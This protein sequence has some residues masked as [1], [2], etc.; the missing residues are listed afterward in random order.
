[1]AINP[2]TTDFV[3]GSILTSAQMN[4]LPRGVI[5]FNTAASAN[6]TLTTSNT[7]FCT[8]TFTLATQRQIQFVGNFPLFDL[9]STQQN[10][11]AEI[12]QGA[13]RVANTQLSVGTTLTQQNISVIRS[14]ALAAGTYTYTL[15]ANVSTGTNRSNSAAAGNVTLVSL[16]AIDLGPA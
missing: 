15:Q 1:M 5:G 8:V 2:I 4:Q 14:Y 3:S 13:T 7:T 9:P 11:N 10:I 6:V 16:T 12:Y